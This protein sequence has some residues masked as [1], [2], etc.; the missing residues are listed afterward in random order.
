LMVDSI[1]GTYRLRWSLV[2]GANPDDRKAPR[3]EAISNDFRF[4]LEK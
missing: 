2:S 3:I 1:D 4:R